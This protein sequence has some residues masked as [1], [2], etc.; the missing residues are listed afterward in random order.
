MKFP[1]VLKNATKLEI[2]IFVLFLIYL[3]FP[4]QTPVWLSPFV[5]SPVGI[6][7]LFCITLYLFLYM[8]PILGIVFV[9]VAYEVL[10]RSASF[11]G[12]GNNGVRSSLIM[13]YTPSEEKKEEVMQK[14]NPPVVGTLEE[15]V[16]SKMAPVGV[17]ESN[18]ILKSSF[19]P[20]ADN[21]R[22]ASYV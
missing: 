16:V 4:I 8:N 5:D 10:R 2:A 3:I 7:L 1:S 12:V 18:P 15:E 9:F 20:V 6:L 11:M 19:A 21:I 17:S 13:Q 14:L 22:N